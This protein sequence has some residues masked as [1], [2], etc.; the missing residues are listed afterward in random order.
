[1]FLPWLS[2]IDTLYDRHPLKPRRHNAFPE[3]TLE[4]WEFVLLPV[5]ARVICPFSRIELRNWALEA[6][7]IAPR[8]HT[9]YHTHQ[10]SGPLKSPWLLGEM[11]GL[12][13]LPITTRIPKAHVPPWAFCFFWLAT[14]YQ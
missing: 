6:A 1:M 9:K 12:D 3:F 8:S 5:P 2:K 7:P 13:F 11:S 4:K 10:H 14:V